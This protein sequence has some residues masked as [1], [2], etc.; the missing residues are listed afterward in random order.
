MVE[1]MLFVVVSLAVL[2]ACGTDGRQLAASNAATAFL[3]ASPAQGCQLMAPDT[4]KAMAASDGTTCAQAL[5][6]HHLPRATAVRRVEVAGQSAQVVLQDQVVF[7]GL[8]PDGWRV[9]AA[10]CVRADPDEQIPYEC[11]VES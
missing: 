1:R 10:G 7:L 9:T 8:F 2:T 6:R 4:A 3:A 11:E 5:A